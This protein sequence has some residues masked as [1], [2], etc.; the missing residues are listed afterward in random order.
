MYH[1]GICPN[2][3][4]SMPSGFEKSSAETYACNGLQKYSAVNLYKRAE[5]VIG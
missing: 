1:R 3:L 5:V 4:Y 2:S